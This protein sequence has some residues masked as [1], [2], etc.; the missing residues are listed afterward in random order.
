MVKKSTLS[1]PLLVLLSLPLTSQASDMHSFALGA[2]T[3]TALVGVGMGVPLLHTEQRHRTQ[4]IALQRQ[5]EADLAAI[6]LQPKS[7]ET[8]KP[9]KD[10]VNH[11]EELTSLRQ[12]IDSLLTEQETLRAAAS[13]NRKLI[14]AYQQQNEITQNA[15][16][17]ELEYL[18]KNQAR[19]VSAA[20]KNSALA[21]ALCLPTGHT[22]RFKIEQTQKGLDTLLD[23]GVKP[24]DQNLLLQSFPAV[25][26][27][28]S[29]AE[30]E[31]LTA[32]RTLFYAQEGALEA[33]TKQTRNL[34]DA[35]AAA[36]TQAR[37]ARVSRT[38]EAADNKK[39]HIRVLRPHAASETDH[40]ES[41]S[42]T[43]REEEQTT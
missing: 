5:H 6:R 16:Q 23:M 20:V 40:A 33:L 34:L 15:H 42:E 21:L 36:E 39:R 12:K 2:V 26:T 30:I 22:T 7:P 19:A 25:L 8:E 9:H 10:P 24:D 32:V 18:R 28:L 31:G 14:T 4:L 13:E 17:E 43:E 35:Q 41:A 29:E 37:T 38:Q 11:S 27:A 3:A 1:L